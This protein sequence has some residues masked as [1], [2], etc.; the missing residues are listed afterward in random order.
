VRQQIDQWADDKISAAEQELD[1]H[2][3]E[4]R[5]ARRQADLAETVQA[6]QAALEQINALEAKRR[7]ARRNIDDVEEKVE[8]ERQDLL[9]QLQARC[10]QRHE[11]QTL[12]V[13]RFE[14]I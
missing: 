3:R 8:Q 9:R 11:R 4:L 13:L 6:Q 10:Q 5:A 1:V 2:R 12:F 14:A 7:R